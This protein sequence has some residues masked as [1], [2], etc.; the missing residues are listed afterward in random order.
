MAADKRP[1]QKGFFAR[2]KRTAS[3][4]AEVDPFTESAS[5]AFTTVFAIP[6]VVIIA[7]TVASI[8]CDANEVRDA[9]YLQVGGFIGSETSKTLQEAVEKATETKSGLFAKIVGVIALVLSATTAFASLQSS[10]NKIWR[11]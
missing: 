9:L 3:S 8:F 2:I 4:F 10:L 11:V 6:G 1:S 7:L 5:L